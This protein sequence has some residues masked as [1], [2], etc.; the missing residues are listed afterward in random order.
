MAARI[1][2][3]QRGVHAVGAA[4]QRRVGQHGG[5]AKAA[6]RVSDFRIAAGDGDRADIRLA[7]TIQHVH[8]HRPAMD[9]GQRL[10]WQPRRRHARRNDNDGIHVRAPLRVG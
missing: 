7:A 8:D 2:L 3:R 1:Q 4:W 10:A 5:T 9:V 6:H